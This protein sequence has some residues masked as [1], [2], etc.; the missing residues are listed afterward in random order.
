[1]SGSS[2]KCGSLY[3]SQPY[4][5][6][7]PVSGTA[8]SFLVYFWKT[9]EESESVLTNTFE[10]N[11]LFAHLVCLQCTW[12]RCQH[13]VVYSYY[14]SSLA[15]STDLKTLLCC[16]QIVLRICVYISTVNFIFITMSI[17]YFHTQGNY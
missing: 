11:I 15:I 10:R 8:L 4:G 5:L 17:L 7:Q 14:Y 12:V 9:K 16:E 13:N 3:V 6:S 1:M 2:R